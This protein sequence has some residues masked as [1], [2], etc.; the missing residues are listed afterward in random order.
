MK[1]YALL[2]LV[3]NLKKTHE[4][5]TSEEKEQYRRAL[6]TISTQMTNE[7]PATAVIQ[8]RRRREF[9]SLLKTPPPSN[10]QVSPTKA[11]HPNSTTN[12]HT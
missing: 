1:L 7:D 8:V 11:P 5:Y 10:D 12:L 6:L 4:K 9:V 3:H 2:A